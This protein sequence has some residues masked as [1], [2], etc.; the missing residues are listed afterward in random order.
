MFRCAISHL[1]LHNLL[2]WSHV[3]GADDKWTEDVRS[4]LRPSLRRRW[5]RVGARPAATEAPRRPIR[6]S[7]TAR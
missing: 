7:S 2:A 1:M 5:G 3:T 4:R 6:A